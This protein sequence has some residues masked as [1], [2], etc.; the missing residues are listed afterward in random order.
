MD[1]FILFL[2]SISLSIDAFSVSLCDGMI[3]SL[4]NKR[5]FFIAGTFGVM[6]GVMP[7]IGYFLGSLFIGYLIPYDGIL[8]FSLFVIIGIKMI[9]DACKNQQ[10]STADF[11]VPSIL[12]QGVATSIDALAVGVTLLSMKVIIWISAPVIA[13]VT[14]SLSL[15][16]LLCGEK[17]VGLFK[18]RAYIAQIIGGAVLI[19]IGVKILVESFI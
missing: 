11:S 1:Y 13:V 14:F 19:L 3:M 16:A 7:I 10:C 17:L 12:L 6:Q 2:L 5:R 4:N 8:S 9:V 18:G 15:L